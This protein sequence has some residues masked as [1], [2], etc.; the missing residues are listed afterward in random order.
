MLSEAEQV[1]PSA[2]G[3]ERSAHVAVTAAALNSGLDG[4][5]WSV[6]VPARTR[7]ER[8]PVVAPPPVPVDQKSALAGRSGGCKRHAEYQNLVCQQQFCWQKF[9]SCPAQQNACFG[10]MVTVTDG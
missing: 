8:F 7:F 6:V 4:Q 9:S 3:D 10:Y 5:F 1:L 2:I